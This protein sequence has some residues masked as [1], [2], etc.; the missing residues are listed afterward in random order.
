MVAWVESGENLPPFVPG[1]DF[2][3]ECDGGGALEDR[4]DD[5]GGPTV[6]GIVDDFFLE[7]RSRAAVW[8]QGYVDKVEESVG[9]FGKIS[10]CHAMVHGEEH[11]VDIWLDGSCVHGDLAHGVT[12][13][14]KGEEGHLVQGVPGLD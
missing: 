5:L 7:R 8:F 6:D 3:R 13:G 9:A 12:Y 11:H 14:G 2:D 4:A 1:N 10:L